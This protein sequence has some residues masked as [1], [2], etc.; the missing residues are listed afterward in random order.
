MSPALPRPGDLDRLSITSTLIYRTNEQSIG[1]SANRRPISK[2]RSLTAGNRVRSWASDLLVVYVDEAHVHGVD[3][4]ED[5]R[6]ALD[7]ALPG[8]GHG[9][10]GARGQEDGLVAAAERKEG[11][12][13]ALNQHHL[14]R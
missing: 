10:G 3:G 7:D 5:V 14:H 4:G 6:G 1:H 9:D 2:N 8:L 12:V 11:E 13:P